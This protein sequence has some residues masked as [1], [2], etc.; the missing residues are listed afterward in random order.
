V[1]DLVG[2]TLMVYSDEKR[3]DDVTASGAD[4]VSLSREATAP[5]QP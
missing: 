2:S 3:G 4:A 5:R 1:L